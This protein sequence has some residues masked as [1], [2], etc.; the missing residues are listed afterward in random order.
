MIL[1]QALSWAMYLVERINNL[2]NMSAYVGD[3][4]PSN[5]SHV[6]EMLSH[7]DACHLSD[8]WP[9]NFDVKLLRIGATLLSIHRLDQGGAVYQWLR[10]RIQVLAH[11]KCICHATMSI[12]HVVQMQQSSCS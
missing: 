6:C 12:A 2:Q 9:E 11:C 8:L 10:S 3:Y 7:P 1:Q 4:A 5:M